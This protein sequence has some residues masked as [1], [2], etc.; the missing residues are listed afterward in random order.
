MFTLFIYLL[1]LIEDLDN[2]FQ[3]DG[4]SSVDVNTVLLVDVYTKL[5]RGERI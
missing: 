3:Y 1:F 4:R 5:G 2:P